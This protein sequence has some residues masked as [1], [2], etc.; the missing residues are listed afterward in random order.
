[1]AVGNLK[2]F[3]EH[4]E[5]GYYLECETLEDDARWHNIMMIMIMIMHACIAS[6]GG[7]T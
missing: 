3:E 4:G 5:L 2:N 6:H 1:M 7:G